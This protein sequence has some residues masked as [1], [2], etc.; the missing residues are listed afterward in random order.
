MDKQDKMKLAYKQLFLI[1]FCS[2]T[3]LLLLS[4]YL[5]TR[6]TIIKAK[7]PSDDT[8]A[9]TEV[10]DP[11]DTVSSNISD[12]TPISK[13]K[14]AITNEDKGSV[15]D[16]IATADEKGS[17]P[18]KTDS[19]SSTTGA[20]IID[21]R[22]VVTSKGVLGIISG[23]KSDKT[24]ASADIF[25]KGGF[26]EGIDAILKGVGSLKAGGKDSTR[27]PERKGKAGIGYGAGYGSGFGGGSGGTDDLIS[28]LMDGD[29]NSLNLK[30][31]GSIKNA[32]DEIQITSYTKV[33]NE[34]DLK[35][36]E[37]LRKIQ[38]LKRK[39]S[40]I[41]SVTKTKLRNTSRFEATG[42]K[43]K[44][45]KTKNKEK[46]VM[47]KEI[48]PTRIKNIIVTEDV[49][50]EMDKETV[51][52]LEPFLDEDETLEE[53]T[54]G[55]IITEKPKTTP[56]EVDDYE[57]TLLRQRIRGRLQN[58]AF[59]KAG[60][61]DDNEEFPFYQKYCAENNSLDIAKKW[62]I[63][64]R[65]IIKV[66]DSDSNTI[67]F[68]T[69]NLHNADDSLV[70]S[71]KTLAS[72]EL[73]LF[74]YMDLGKEYRFITDYTLSINGNRPVSIKKNLEQVITIRLNNPRVLPQKIPIQ[75]CFLLDATGSM[76]DEIEKLKDVIFSIHTRITQHPSKPEVAFSTV[77]YRDRSDWFIAKGHDFTTDIDK[78]QLNLETVKAGGGGDYPED[79]DAGFRYVFD[80][81][82]WKKNTLKFIFLMGDAPPHLDYNDKRDYNWAM[83]Y[84]RKNGVMICPIGASGLQ[85]IG[86]FIYR[87]LGVLT[88]GPYI[89]LHYGETGNSEG[90]GTKA[91]P[92]K[93]SHHTGANYS[94]ERLDDIVVDI[95]NTELGYLTGK[96]FLIHDFPDPNLENDHLDRRLENLILQ[97]TRED[98]KLT[99]KKLVLVP[100]DCTDSIL[101]PLSEYL[102]GNALAKF[103]TIS[104]MQLIE[105]EKLEDLLKEQ[106][107]NQTGITETN[108]ETYIGKLLSADYMV[109]SSLNFLGSVRVCHM[110]MVD[111][112]SGGIVSAARIKL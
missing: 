93:V 79:I 56:K 28:S 48:V 42:K 85:P 55:D 54:T 88:N 47:E 39:K 71:A 109:F 5:R 31:R 24:V 111:C 98:K 6:P 101:Q 94:V 97:I 17:G 30:K 77:A 29:T 1:L 21:E 57:T 108:G 92:G 9:V 87:Q 27:S 25:G 10:L 67:P 23:Q 76:R 69:V 96:E 60:L 3:V 8:V 66:I 75:I 91:D 26:T 103:S 82:H 19:T 15:K 46:V 35:K 105:R 78:F 40:K 53:E 34:E 104:S 62:H 16:T 80:K 61:H 49:E 22:D 37:L 52:I 90:A 106:A 99:D 64:E 102:W 84:A 81:L 41:E 4:C 110:R 65:F 44:S 68:A 11:H 50:E 59:A 107:L 63:N 70:F 18:A 12:T 7:S 20:E 73:I 32:A 45:K 51:A 112:K 72:G 43:K 58:A 86:E 83:N 100:F 95:I 14:T 33:P 74:P 36:Q 13:E 38:E 2:F 89:F